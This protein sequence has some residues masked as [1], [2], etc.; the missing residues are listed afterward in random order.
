M[1]AALAA[2]KAQLASALG[3][4]E[5]IVDGAV[6]AI[7]AASSRRVAPLPLSSP[8]PPLPPCR[9]PPSLRRRYVA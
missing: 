4:E 1:A 9:L 3:W 5:F 7:V 2:L 8:P 6:D